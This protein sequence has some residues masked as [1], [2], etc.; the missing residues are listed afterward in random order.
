MNKPELKVSNLRSMK[1]TVKDG[2]NRVGQGKPFKVTDEGL[3]IIAAHFKKTHPETRKFTTA[4]GYNEPD[5]DITILCTIC[6]TAIGK[7]KNES[8]V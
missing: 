5:D 6:Q 1:A 2:Q 4:F 7:M 3:E 8:Q